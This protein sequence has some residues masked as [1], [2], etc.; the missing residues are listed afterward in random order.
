MVKR[1]MSSGLSDVKNGWIPRRISTLCCSACLS[2]PRVNSMLSVSGRSGKSFWV[3]LEASPSVR[4][5]APTVRLKFP[6]KAPHADLQRMAK[7][8]GHQHLTRI[9]WRLNWDSSSDV[10]LIRNGERVVFEVAYINEKLDV[11]RLVGTE[12]L[13]D[14]LELLFGHRRDRCCATSN[15]FEHRRIARPCLV[16][17]HTGHLLA[18]RCRGNCRKV[19]QL[20]PK[21]PAYVRR[22]ILPDR[23][24]VQ[25]KKL[26]R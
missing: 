19:I 4:T 22:G 21:L 7:F 5:I 26:R 3:T 16:E 15:A 11:N 18:L 1:S 9:R 23:F 17:Q 14:R 12:Q 8:V 25:G 24:F 2:H 20:F 10:T 6:E 13:G